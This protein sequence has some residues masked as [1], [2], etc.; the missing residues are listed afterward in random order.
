[1]S[2]GSKDSSGSMK[3]LVFQTSN[4]SLIGKFL[5]LILS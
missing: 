1:M 3:E 2:F 4:L 5:V